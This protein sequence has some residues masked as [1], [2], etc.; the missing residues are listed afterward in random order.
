VAAHSPRTWPGRTRSV[1]PCRR[2]L[3]DPPS[4]PGTC[5]ISAARQPPAKFKLRFISQPHTC[6]KCRSTM[7]P[8][9]Y[10]CLLQW[11]NAPM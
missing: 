6:K 5:R 7:E 8:Q 2:A 3:S 10:N 4:S 9:K 11:S 1:G